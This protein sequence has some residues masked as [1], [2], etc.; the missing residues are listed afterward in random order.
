MISIGVKGPLEPKDA[1]ERQLS[2]GRAPQVC[3]QQ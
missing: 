2:M 1:K 3:Q